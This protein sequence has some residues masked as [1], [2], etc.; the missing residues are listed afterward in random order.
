MKGRKGNQRREGREGM[1]KKGGKEREG[2]EERKAKGREEKERK[3]G[4]KLATS[5]N[6]F[7]CFCLLTLLESY[8]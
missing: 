7:T 5:R 8:L 4:K 3:E 1:G 2:R 6:N